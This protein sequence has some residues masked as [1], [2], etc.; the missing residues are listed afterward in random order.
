MAPMINRLKPRFRIWRR[1]NSR[2]AAMTLMPTIGSK[3]GQWFKIRWTFAALRFKSMISVP[4]QKTENKTR[5]GI[6]QVGGL[7]AT[8][9]ILIVIPV[10]VLIVIVI[11]LLVLIPLLISVP[12]HIR[13][14]IR[15]HIRAHI[16]G[17]IRVG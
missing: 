5:K 4:P 12:R 2:P 8:A 1:S 9:I 11:P 16:R 14:H 3:T 6:Y 17:H 13:A 7:W 10:L 15:G